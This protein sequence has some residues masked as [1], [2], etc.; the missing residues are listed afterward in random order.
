MF[1]SKLL[2]YQNVKPLKPAILSHFGVP[3]LD[4]HHYLP[5]PTITYHYLPLPTIANIPKLPVEFSVAH[6][7]DSAKALPRCWMSFVIVGWIW[8]QRRLGLWEKTPIYGVQ[9]VSGKYRK[10]RIDKHMDLTHFFCPSFEDSNDSNVQMDLEA[11]ATRACLLAQNSDAD[12][13][14]GY[15]PKHPETQAGHAVFCSRGSQVCRM[16]M[17]VIKGHR[18][19]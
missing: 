12:Q 18:L 5:L 10:L 8:C 19:H 4:P 2:V 9:V 16:S 6:P 7:V 3:K 11:T 15:T 1:N 13:L 17:Q 14:E